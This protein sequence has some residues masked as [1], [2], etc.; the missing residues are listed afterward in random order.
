MM[1]HSS[2]AVCEDES[3]AKSG[4]VE[5]SERGTVSVWVLKDDNY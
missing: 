5:G 3:S 2:A 1:E 4:A